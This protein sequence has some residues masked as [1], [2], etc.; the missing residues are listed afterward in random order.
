VNHKFILQNSGDLATIERRCAGGITVAWLILRLEFL[1][2][3]RDYI[4]FVST[5]IVQEFI[6]TRLERAMLHRGNNGLQFGD[7]IVNRR[8]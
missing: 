7:T 6:H 4:F 3:N 1:P 8:A 2:Q 5:R